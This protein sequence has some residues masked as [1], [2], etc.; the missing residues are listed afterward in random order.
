MNITSAVCHGGLT[1]KHTPHVL[2]PVVSVLSFYSCLFFLKQTG[3]ITWAWQANL[4]SVYF[5][6]MHT[7]RHRAAHSDHCWELLRSYLKQTTHIRPL[8]PHIPHNTE[9]QQISSK[10]WCAEYIDWVLGAR[11]TKQG[12]LVLERNSISAVKRLITF[13]IK[14]FVYIMYV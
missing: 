8:I 12:K 9:K 1:D 13:K 3:L 2:R 14:V 10:H 11:F 7:R 5:T 4:S 6:W